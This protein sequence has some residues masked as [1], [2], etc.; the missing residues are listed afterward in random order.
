M[1]ED[2]EKR[3]DVNHVRARRRDAT[4]READAIAAASKPMSLKALLNFGKPRQRLYEPLK[5]YRK[6]GSAVKEET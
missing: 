4:A 1:V 6:F 2:V 3:G 5:R